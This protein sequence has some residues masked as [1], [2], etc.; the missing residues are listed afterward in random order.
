MKRKV[1]FFITAFASLG[2]TAMAQEYLTLYARSG[3]PTQSW[4]VS[5]VR[6]ITFSPTDVTFWMKQGGASYTYAYSA[7]R[8]IAFGDED[9]IAVKSLALP[10]QSSIV[11]DAG[12][13]AVIVNDFAQGGQLQVYSVGGSRV[14]AAPVRS[15]QREYQLPPLPDGIYIARLSGTANP[16]SIK[17]KTNKH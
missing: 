16:Q 17:F 2:G 9:P 4:E 10:Q 6:R 11:Y 13:N 7:A 12:R 8:R 14:W 15:P 5:K 1:L 3:L